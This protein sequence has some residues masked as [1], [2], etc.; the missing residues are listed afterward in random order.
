MKKALLLFT[1]L[2]SV[3]TLAHAQD[4]NQ[5]KRQ[6]IQKIYSDPENGLLLLL[7]KYA[8]HDFKAVFKEDEHYAQGELG[9]IDYDVVVSG[10]DLNHKEI[11]RSLK[12]SMLN[13]GNVGVSYRNLGNPANLVYVMQCRNNQCLVDDILD[14]GS[15]FKDSIRSCIANN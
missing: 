11:R 14:D 8:S 4:F 9:C 3:S 5:Q 7:R 13:D 6:I 15:S 2:L 12:I 1:A 10:Q